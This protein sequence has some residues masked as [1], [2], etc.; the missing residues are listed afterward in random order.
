MKIGTLQGSPGCGCA[1]EREKNRD[2]EKI[3]EGLPSSFGRRDIKNGVF[4]IGDFFGGAGVRFMTVVPKNLKE[5]K[6]TM[7]FPDF[8]F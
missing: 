8:L 1:G 3:F 2:F 4:D 6:F 5:Q 7:P